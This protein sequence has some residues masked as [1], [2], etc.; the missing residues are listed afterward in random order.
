M[1]STRG[2]KLIYFVVAAGMSVAAAGR[3]ET[4]S[5][6]VGQTQTNFPVLSEP[7]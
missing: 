7:A 5:I 3:W 2:W 6:P 1:R 4:S